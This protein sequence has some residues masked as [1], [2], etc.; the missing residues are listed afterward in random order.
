[1]LPKQRGKQKPWANAFTFPHPLIGSGQG[2]FHK[3]RALR[4]FEDDIQEREQTVV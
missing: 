3:P 2:N 4:L 1:L